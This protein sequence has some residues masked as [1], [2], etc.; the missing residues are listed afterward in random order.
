MLV[1]WIGFLTQFF[2]SLISSRQIQN[3]GGYKSLITINKSMQCF[4]PNNM[5]GDVILTQD[6]PLLDTDAF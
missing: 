5:V 3:R 1:I 4:T 2:P 6:Q